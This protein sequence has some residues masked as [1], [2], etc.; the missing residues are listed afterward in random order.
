MSEVLPLLPLSTQAAD[1]EKLLLKAAEHSAQKLAGVTTGD[2]ATAHSPNQNRRGSA[3]VPVSSQAP[4]SKCPLELSEC[5]ASALVQELVALLCS[6][7]AS[8]SA[9]RLC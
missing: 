2:K 4:G 5:P 1:L 9:F 8:A 7:S 3:T 6:T